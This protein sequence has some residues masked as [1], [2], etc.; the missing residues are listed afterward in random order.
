MNQL[1]LIKTI[2]GLGLIAVASSKKMSGSPVPHI[3]FAFDGAA[4][5]GP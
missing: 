2:D 4:A 1:R 3:Y 5:A